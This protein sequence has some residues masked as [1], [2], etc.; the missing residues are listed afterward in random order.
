MRSFIN[1]TI[2]SP[3]KEKI[4]DLVFKD[5]DL[6]LFPH[7]GTGSSIHPVIPIQSNIE[8]VFWSSSYHKRSRN[9]SLGSS[10]IQENQVSSYDPPVMPSQ[11]F[12]QR[13]RNFCRNFSQKRAKF[14]NHSKYVICFP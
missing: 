1:D 5:L 6:S 9:G 14:W 8:D 4:E 7:T 3:E 2:I 11:T 13:K 10:Q 12:F